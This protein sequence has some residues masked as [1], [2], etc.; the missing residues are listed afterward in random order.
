MSLKK[1]VPPQARGGKGWLLVLA[2]GLMAC[3]VMGLVLV[4]SNIERMDTTYFINIA[5]NELRERRDLRAKLQVERERLLSPYE[6]R[7]RAEE[8]G[9]REPRPG[10][11]RR[12]EIQ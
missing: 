11:V 8:F 3:M 1:S 5:Q 7:R 6:L 2:L 4:W 9:M 10:Q 12:M